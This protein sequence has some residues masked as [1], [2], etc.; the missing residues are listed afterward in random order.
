MPLWALLSVLAAATACDKQTDE[1]NRQAGMRPAPATRRRQPALHG[2]PGEYFVAA[3]TL[4]VR[5]DPGVGA[6]ADSLY[7]GRVVTVYEVAEGWGRIARTGDP[8]RWVEMG[9]LSRAKPD[10][11][12]VA[13]GLRDPRIDPEGIPLAGE[14][15]L[16]QRDVDLVWMGANWALRT[17][18]CSEV[19]SGH[20][21]LS[22]RGYYYVRCGGE[23][24]FFTESSIR[25]DTSR[26]VAGP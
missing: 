10:G 21:S 7:L 4:A 18:R 25:A 24:V 13:P 3:G 16:S 17:G 2:A 23:T 22:K 26:A 19:Q 5:S 20:K 9:G 15:G 6:P 8:P 12:E 1:W 11:R 14:E